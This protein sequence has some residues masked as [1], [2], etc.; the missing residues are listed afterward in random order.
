MSM[1]SASHP[2]KIEITVDN[3]IIGPDS[4]LFFVCPYACLGGQDV[5]SLANQS[6]F[7]S[8]SRILY[9]TY[10]QHDVMW[11][12]GHL[13]WIIMAGKLPRDIEPILE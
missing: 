8:P 6:T 3:F 2:P 4:N 7:L 13:V 11:M 5:H 1:S 10:E 12:W 9:E